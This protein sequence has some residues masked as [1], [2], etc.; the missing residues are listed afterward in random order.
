MRS[1]ARASAGTSAGTRF[2][3][4][5]RPA[6]TTSGSAAAGSRASSGP[7]YSPSSTVSSPFT[8]AARRRRAWS[9]EK[10]KARC[11]TRR[12]SDCTA[13]PMRPPTGPRYSRQYSPLQTSCQSTTSRKRRSGRTS[14]A[15][16]SEKYGNEAVWTTS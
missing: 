14:A 6:N 2:S 16:S 9:S 11:G 4:M 12:Q 5:W 1:R 3:G 15:A 13:W 8:G 10:Q 7:A